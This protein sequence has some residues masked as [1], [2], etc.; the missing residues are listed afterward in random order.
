M[1]CYLHERILC[2]T[3]RLLLAHISG[4]ELETALQAQYALAR[5]KMPVD[6]KAFSIEHVEEAS[7]PSSRPASSLAPEHTALGGP[8]QARGP[9]YAG[10]GSNAQRTPCS[11]EEA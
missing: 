3:L 7:T 1:L 2:T 4:R 8:S 6:L 5:E 10:G 11:K 9:K